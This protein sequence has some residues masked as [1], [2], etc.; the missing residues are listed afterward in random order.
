MNASRPR[1]AYFILTA[2]LLVRTAPIIGG[3]LLKGDGFLFT[4][5]ESD[6]LIY[7]WGARSILSSGVNEFH[8]FPPV[9][10]L[11]IAGL[12][13]LGGGSVVV[14]SLATALIGWLSVAALYLLAR[15]I[16]DERTA[17]IASLLAGFYPNFIFYGMSL[18]PE[19]LTIFFITCSFLLLVKYYTTHR[20]LFLICAGVVWGLAS[21][22]RGGLHLFSFG[23]AA[24]IVWQRRGSGW[25]ETLKSACLM[26]AAIYCTISAVGFMAAPF[27]GGI[28]LNSKSGMGSALHG[29]NR[30]MN[31][32]PDYGHVRG[33][34][35]YEINLAHDEWPA[36]VQVYSDDLM[37]KNSLKILA[38]FWAF[39]MQEPR[40]YMK[41]GI[42]RLS[43]MWSPNQLII[44]Y[45]KQNLYYRSAPVSD[46]LCLLLSM[47][48]AAVLCAGCAGCFLSKDFFR[49]LFALFVLF[50]CLLI[51]FTV[52][53]A[54]LRLPLMPFFMMYAALFCSMA[55]G[56]AVR[57][58]RYTAI[59]VS[60]LCC[61][62]AFNAVYRYQDI[63]ISPGEFNVRQV[64]LSAELGFSKT[65][66]FLLEKKRS[67]PHYTE[68]QRARLKK[69]ERTLH[70]RNQG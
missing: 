20:M 32:N 54:K 66:L 40:A 50:Y 45:I 52:G 37:Q 68:Q 63:A 15:E 17:V 22:A 18:Y 14:P 5:G 48:F 24:A 47:L 28:S 6:P 33:S 21:Q 36:G 19:T 3:F 59:P 42:E 57:F 34:L 67:F 46:A 49:P 8:F 69:I 56:C 62:I 43:F 12:L 39:V 60:V 23:I 2:V 7:L 64:E 11:F 51:F 30:L 41:S 16:F 44:K 29:A 26:L 53:N 13:Y 10:F 58:T 35:L 4:T 25:S 27:Y 55:A 65:A 31:C 70:E 9:N 1:Y 61:V 38:D